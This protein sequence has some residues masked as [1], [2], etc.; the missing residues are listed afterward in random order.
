MLED[1]QIQLSNSIIEFKKVGV[2]SDLLKKISINSKLES[3]IKSTS[4]EEK[5]ILLKNIEVNKQLSFFVEHTCNI[6]LG[7]ESLVYSK[8]E[9]YLLNFIV[10]DVSNNQKYTEVYQTLILLNS[11]YFKYLIRNNVND[12]KIQIVSRLN[13]NQIEKCISYLVKEWAVIGLTF[14]SFYFYRFDEKYIANFLNNSNEISNNTV[15]NLEKNHFLILPLIEYNMKSLHYITIA[16][17][18]FFLYTPNNRLTINF[19]NHTTLKSRLLN[20]YKQLYKLKIYTLLNPYSNQN[21]LFLNDNRLIFQLET[22]FFVINHQGILLNEYSITFTNNPLI[23]YSNGFYIKSNYSYYSLILKESPVLNTIQNS[24]SLN[25][26]FDIFSNKSIYNY[27]NSFTP[28]SK[29]SLNFN[30]KKYLENLEELKILCFLNL[31]YKQV[32]FK[33]IKNQ[34][35]NYLEETSLIIEIDNFLSFLNSKN[36]YY[37]LESNLSDGKL[38]LLLIVSFI[39][40]NNKLIDLMLR[41]SHC[42]NDSKNLQD[43]GMLN[44]NQIFIVRTFFLSTINFFVEVGLEYKLVLEGVLKFLTECEYLSKILNF[45]EHENNNKYELYSFFDLNDLISTIIS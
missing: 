44:S 40:N 1:L 26:K 14:G 9:E 36:I 12:N 30:N 29:I 32:E 24:C 42:E 7:Q 33:N 5:P 6:Q 38:I 28:L 2:Q 3:Y 13:L 17:K 39:I 41:S 35:S 18:N 20:I 43:L 15:I 31:K 34:I 25:N 27:N 8:K 11:N 16:N 37:F 19:N 4:K 22:D 21:S 23:Y 45:K 10:E